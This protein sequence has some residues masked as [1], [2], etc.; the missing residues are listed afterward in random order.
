M[1]ISKVCVFAAASRRVDA[2][3]F[4]QARALGA[5]LASRG[6][7]LIYGGGNHGLMGALADSA[8]EAGGKVIGVLPRFMDEVEWGHRNLTE[9]R[10][11]ETMEDRLG[12]M[13]SEAEAFI[14][15]PGGTGTLEELFFILSRKRLGLHIGPVVIV[16]YKGYFDPTL[17]ALDRC[18][19]EKFLDQRHAGMWTVA[20]D[21]ESAV[22]V[23]LA[24][25]AWDAGARGFA[26]P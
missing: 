13:L 21:A 26:I 7:T 17:A 15:L 3:Y 11:V 14:T 12:G 16:N 5:S 20:P 1:A 8:L 18:V 4:Q 25:P 23:M 10:L 9:L 24:S 22:E 19:S 2:G 6:M